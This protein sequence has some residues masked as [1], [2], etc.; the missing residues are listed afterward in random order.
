[1]MQLKQPK[2]KGGSKYQAFADKLG[3]LVYE[4]LR[5]RGYTSRAAYDNV[6]S[7]LGHESTYGTSSVAKNN[8]NYGGYGFNGK[9]YSVFKNDQ[10]FVD[11]YL[12]TMANR[13]KQALQSSDVRDFA[14]AL[15]QKGYYQ[16]PLEDYTRV[17]VGMKSL[18]KAAAKHYGQAPTSRQSVLLN[19]PVSTEQVLEQPIQLPVNQ[20]VKTNMSRPF[21]QP[22]SKGPS[23]DTYMPTYENYN[24]PFVYTP[25]FE[26]PPI[27]ST[28]GAL[29]SEPIFV[30]RPVLQSPN[31]TQQSTESPTYAYGKD[32]DIPYMYMP[33][34]PNYKFA[35]K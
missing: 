32:Y 25:Q 22:I 10:Q 1:M 8:H 5:K 24:T 30:Q 16:A 28:M 27:E 9:G 26:T 21:D 18:R 12:D 31:V 11:A 14:K 19:P 7:Q 13:Y 29:I 34:M 6:M 2:G 3:P 33:M 4:G 35:Y 17:L 15:K 23:L 20:A